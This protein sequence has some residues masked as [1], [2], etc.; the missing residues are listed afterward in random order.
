[1]SKNVNKRKLKVKRL[2]EPKFTEKRNLYKKY[3]KANG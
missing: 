1:M 3:Q 2:N